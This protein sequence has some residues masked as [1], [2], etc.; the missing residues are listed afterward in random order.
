MDH[1][2]KN[3][4]LKMVFYYLKAYFIWDMKRFFYIKHRKLKKLEIK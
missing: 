1:L 4:S 2:E 3:L